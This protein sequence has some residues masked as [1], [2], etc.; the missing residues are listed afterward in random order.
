M[1]YWRY[2]AIGLVFVFLLYYYFAV[3]RD[4]DQHDTQ[5]VNQQQTTTQKQ[6]ETK[7]DEQAP[8]LIKVT[9]IELGSNQNQWKF[10]VA[11]TTHSVDL[12]QDPTKVMSLI[13]DQGKTYLPTAWEGPGPGGHHREGTLSFKAIQPLPKYI[14]LEVKDVGGIPERSFR[15]DL[16]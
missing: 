7:T 4:A 13:D 16:E 12:D 3:Y 14:E 10:T 11:F 8:V 15:W 2:I 6:W 9:P 5:N 1:K